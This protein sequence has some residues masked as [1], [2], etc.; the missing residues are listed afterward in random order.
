MRGFKF[1]NLNIL[2]V[3]ADGLEDNTLLLDFQK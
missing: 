2:V 3:R 1:V